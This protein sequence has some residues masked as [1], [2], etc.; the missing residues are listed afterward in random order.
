M[1]TDS[2]A[3][4]YATALAGLDGVD[5]TKIENSLLQVR[6]VFLENADLR[7]YFESP[8]IGVSH[9]KKAIKSAF[10]KIVEETVTNLLSLLIDKGREEALVGI[11]DAFVEIMDRKLNRVRPRVI[12]SHE[13]DKKGNDEIVALVEQVVDK[14]RDQF[15]LGDV[16]GK[17]DF[18]VTTEV[19]ADILGG[20][21]LRIG[22]YYWD[23]TVSRYL[24]DWRQ[25]IFARHIDK[26]QLVAS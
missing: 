18:F 11:C 14:N 12:L 13:Y 25:R 17:I 23:A 2:V 3:Y 16:K 15:G 1:N 20:I 10:G 4:Q 7:L 6:Q 8:R 22:D 26:E 5:G 21:A 24:R 9:K 19:D